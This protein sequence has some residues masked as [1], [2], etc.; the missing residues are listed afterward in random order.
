MKAR[1]PAAFAVAAVGL[2]AAGSFTVQATQPRALVVVARHDLRVGQRLTAADL[3]VSAIP[4]GG[5]RGRLLLPASLIGLIPGEIVSRPVIAG[6]AVLVPDIH[7]RTV[8]VAPL[9]TPA[10]LACGN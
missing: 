2:L 10:G 9:P 6:G 8:H 3:A 4:D 7:P 1:G 5:A